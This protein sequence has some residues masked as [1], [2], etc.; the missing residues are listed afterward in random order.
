[1]SSQGNGQPVRYEVRLSQQTKAA[2][3]QHHRRAAQA[4]KGQHFLASLR[5]IIERLR[6]DPL[7]FGEPL[8][9]LPALKLLVCQAAVLPIIV[10]FAVHE[11][12]PLVFIRQFRVMP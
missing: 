5:H 12:R 11:E 3:K 6:Q 4:G 10:D 9:R 2:L 7:A 8:Y 1:M